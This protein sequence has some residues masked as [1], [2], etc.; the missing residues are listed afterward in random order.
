MDP[1]FTIDFDQ[2]AAVYTPG[3]TVRGTLTIQNQSALNAL[4][5][6][7]CIHG[8]V[9]TFWRKYEQNDK[10]GRYYRRSEHI[11]YKSV[12]KILNGAAQ[13]WSSIENT[14]NKI[15][16][17]VNIFPF[18]F[19]LPMSCPPSFEGS[20]GNVRYSVHVELHRPWR[21]DVETKRVFSVI[22][23]VDLNTIPKTINPMVSHACMHSG[24][25]GTKEVKV[26][27]NLPKSGYTPGEVIPITLSIH[28]HTKK[29][30]HYAK[31]S[32]IQHVHYQAQQEN[33]HLFPEQHCHKHCD[34][35]TA[36]SK[37]SEMEKSFTV[38]CCSEGQVQLALVLPNP[39]VPT[40]RTG[41]IE[42]D[43][44]VMVEVEKCE[45]LRCEFPVTIGTVPIGMGVVMRGPTY[46]M[47]QQDLPV[48][49]PPEYQDRVEVVMTT[50]APSAPPPEYDDDHF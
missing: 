12:I 38:N 43:Y 39:L 19:Q 44:V 46:S 6:K 30:V 8:E 36:E 33:S 21:L 22:P 17:G 26:T 7:I 40:F 15:P 47:I 24:F 28:N 16:A 10:T 5:L 34:H 13:P 14:T 48:E 42:V 1:I 11:N 37:L 31:A 49:A 4:S 45:K 2:P 9:V 23:I 41:I 3:Q 50:N 20:H 35:K 25:F 29:P 32:L 27:V 18:V